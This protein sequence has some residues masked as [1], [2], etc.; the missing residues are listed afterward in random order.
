MAILNNA[1]VC[2]DESV[3][4]NINVGGSATIAG[5][6]STNAIQVSNINLDGKDFPKPGPSNDGLIMISKDSAYQFTD[7]I[8]CNGGGGSSRTKVI[9]IPL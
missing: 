7:V 5:S 3:V 4:G 9:G 8:D 6:V 1:I 2:G